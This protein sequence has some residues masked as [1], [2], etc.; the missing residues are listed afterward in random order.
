MPYISDTQKEIYGMTAADYE[1][2]LA[3]LERVSY[4]VATQILA[5]SKNTI[6]QNRPIFQVLTEISFRSG[7]YVHRMQMQNS[8]YLKKITT[9]RPVSGVKM[10]ISKKGRSIPR[11]PRKENE[12]KKKNTPQQTTVS[13]PNTKRQYSTIYLYFRFQ[14]QH[15]I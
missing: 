10:F 9:V 4:L 12:Q 7:S 2:L 6:T 14:F 13:H 15:F 1:W 5:F 11:W 8:E 3:A